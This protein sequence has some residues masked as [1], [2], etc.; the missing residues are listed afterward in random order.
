MN[1]HSFYTLEYVP[2]YPYVPRDTS[3][4]ASADCNWLKDPQK[5]E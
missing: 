4:C 1:N 3:V 5:S 2:S